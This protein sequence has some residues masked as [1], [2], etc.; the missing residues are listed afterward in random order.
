MK[1][2]QPS[3]EDK[4]LRKRLNEWRWKMSNDLYG[5]GFIRGFGCSTFMPNAILNRICDAAHYNLVT[6]VDTLMKE[7][8]WHFSQEHGQKVVDIISEMQA[9]PPPPS[10]EQTPVAATLKTGP[11]EPS[12]VGC[13]QQ[14]HSRGLFF[15]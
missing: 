1:S 3:K 4:A 9:T 6:S 7:T 5:E 13:D 11:L 10:P 14:G 15:F 8:D 12:C 2:Y